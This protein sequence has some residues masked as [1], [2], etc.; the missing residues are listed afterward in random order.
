[1]SL[2]SPYGDSSGPHADLPHWKRTRRGF[3][4]D[5]GL[6]RRRSPGCSSLLTCPLNTTEGL[7]K[8]ELYLYSYNLLENLMDFVETYGFIPNGGRKYYLNRSQ[9]PV[10]VQ[11]SC[12]SPRCRLRSVLTSLPFRSVDGRCLR[13]SDRQRLD[14]GQ[15]PADHGDRTRVVEAEPYHL[16]Q[17]TVHQQDPLCRKVRRE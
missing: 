16:R 2:H 12:R 15:G 17:V 8:S 1:V 7:L 3:V 6:V 10:L 4:L 13:S 11:V 9:P 5:L 14:P